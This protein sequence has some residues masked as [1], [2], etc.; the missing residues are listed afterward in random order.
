[1]CKKLVLQLCIP[2]RCHCGAQVDAHA[3]HS[4]RCKRASGRTTRHHHLNELIVRA[5]SAV[6]IPNIKEPQGLCLGSTANAQM[7]S[8]WFLGKVGSHS[9]GTSQLSAHWRSLMWPWR[10][11]NHPLQLRWRHRTK[12]PI[13]YAAYHYFPV[14]VESL[15]P[16]NESATSSLRSKRE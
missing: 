13:K 3:R 4:F 10:P 11:G 2:H 6:S 7:A 16:A 5:V 15:G 12:L 8:L 9:Y 1:M 14:A